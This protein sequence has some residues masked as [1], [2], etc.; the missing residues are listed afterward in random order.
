MKFVTFTKDGKELPGVITAD[1]ARVH[2]LEGWCTLAGFI[3][4]YEPRGRAVAEALA[5]KDGGYPLADVKLEAPIP[6]PR[7]GVLCV[8]LNYIAHAI[9]SAAAAGNE[10]KPP[11]R[12]SYFIKRVNR[13]V[14]PDGEIPSHSAI[15][16]KLDYE[17]ELTVV[18]GK[19]CRNV[20]R[21]DAFAH[22]FGYTVGNDISA[23]EIQRGYNQWAFGKSLDGSAPMGP[24]I[25]TIDEFEC[26][27]A[28]RVTSKVNGEL[29]QDSNTNDFI[30][31]I[32]HLIS[33]LSQGITLEP[34]DVIMTGTPS[35]VGM[36]FTPPKFLRAGDV[37]ELEIE[38][39]GKLVNRIVE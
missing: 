1:G 9:E 7:N 28:L 29:R 25:V 8:G 24:W 14:G 2:P 34:G 5:A 36:G 37:V 30:F 27:P 31:D 16:Q 4:D 26:P 12:P 3:A 32:P 17:V 13:A 20:K 18:I 39:I 10:Y 19:T 22:V 15:T 21:E 33:E 11:E 23:R 38:G 6:H 35:G